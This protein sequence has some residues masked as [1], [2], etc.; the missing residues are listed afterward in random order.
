MQPGNIGNL[1]K[2]YNN[3]HFNDRFDTVVNTEYD[4]TLDDTQQTA[5]KNAILTAMRG[6]K[7]QEV[8][9]DH[10]SK[11]F[12]ATGNSLEGEDLNSDKYKVLATRFSP[13]GNTAMIKN[14]KGE[15]IRYNMPVGVN[16]YNEEFRDESV[17]TLSQIQD[18]IN[19]ST[20]EVQK[21]ALI[22]KYNEQLQN[23]YLY[24]SQLGVQN[25]VKEQELDAFGK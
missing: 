13:F 24:H 22:D 6:T 17:K 5:M 2:K 11:K 14:D 12:T 10:K 7:L 8:D 15:V 3:V 4:F 18:R 23:A 21:Q 19:K 16:P 9:F 20:A 25:K 1:W